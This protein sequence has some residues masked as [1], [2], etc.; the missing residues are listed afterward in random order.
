MS[1]IRSLPYAG[2]NGVLLC[3]STGANQ[4]RQA[5]HEHFPVA[6]FKITSVAQRP[7]GVGA[8][9]WR[10]SAARNAAASNTGLKANTD[11]A[12]SLACRPRPY[13]AAARCLFVSLGRYWRGIGIK[14]RIKLLT[15]LVKSIKSVHP[16]ILI[17]L[18]LLGL[19]GSPARSATR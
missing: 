18:N 6:G 1:V 5:L 7:R 2:R 16:N 8:I 11:A 4:E 9:S 15:G 19:A 10:C 3:C 12:C 17:D 14:A 13:W